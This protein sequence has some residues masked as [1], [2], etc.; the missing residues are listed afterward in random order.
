MKLPVGFNPTEFRSG[1]AFVAGTTKINLAMAGSFDAGNTLKA[2]RYTNADM[3]ISQCIRLH[4][5]N[6]ITQ[7]AHYIT[8]H[9]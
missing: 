8:F 6:S 7:I 2:L 5:K 9:F 3:K 4:I 1:M